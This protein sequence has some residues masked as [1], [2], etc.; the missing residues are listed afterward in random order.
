MYGHITN[1][2]QF[3][4]LI[5]NLST[6]VVLTW[7]CVQRG[8]RRKVV[9]YVRAQMKPYVYDM[10]RC[11]ADTVIGTLACIIIDVLIDV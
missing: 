8:R 2:Q 9:V 7:K 4:L 10:L 1:V 5:T 6:Q 11:L 3:L